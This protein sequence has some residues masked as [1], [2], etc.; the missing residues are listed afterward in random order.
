MR[1]PTS[2]PTFNLFTTDVRGNPVWL[3]AV[4]DLETAH[5]RL[6]QLASVN[7]GEYFIFDLRTQQIVGSLVSTSE[8]VT[9]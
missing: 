9:C 6:S 2:L 5:L 3:E 8:Q 7:P 4:G 1:L